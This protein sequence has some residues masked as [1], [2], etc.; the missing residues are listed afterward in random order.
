MTPDPASSTEVPSTRPAPRKLRTYTAEDEIYGPAMA[1]VAR[2]GTFRDGLAGV[3]RTLLA[4][5]AADDS[6]P[7]LS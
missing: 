2:L 5:W 1:K 4:E 7:P 3:V 6:R